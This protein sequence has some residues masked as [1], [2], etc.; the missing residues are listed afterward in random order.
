MALAKRLN[1]G[2][3]PRV[4]VQS[5]EGHLEVRG[6]SRSEVIIEAHDPETSIDEQEGGVVINSPGNCSI[7]LPDTGQLIIGHAMGTL[8]LKDLSLAAEVGQV[9]GH[10]S[11][12][13][14]GGLTINSVSGELRGRDVQGDLTVGDVSGHVTLKDIEGQVRID[15]IEGHFYGS[16]TPA[17]LHLGR[18]EGNFSLRSDFNP[19]TASD[20][21]VDGH[22]SFSIPENTNVQ[23]R[24]RAEG[25]VRVE[26]GMNASA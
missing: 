17:G 1:L 16:N 20:I 6:T 18:V 11:A 23:F 4:E 15:V 7:R 19:G 13:R 8:Q 24:I 14:T 2:A 10:V 22:A 9:D 25:K 26:Q 21:T 12:R 5:C 3:N